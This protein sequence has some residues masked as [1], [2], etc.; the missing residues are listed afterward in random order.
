MEEVYQYIKDIKDMRVKVTTQRD[1][2]FLLADRRVAEKIG[3]FIKSSISHHTSKIGRIKETMSCCYLPVL[4]DKLV[5]EKFAKIQ[6]PFEMTILAK[7]GYISL[8]TLA[9][10]FS[11][12]GSKLTVE[13]VKD[14][15]CQNESDEVPRYQWNWEDDSVFKPYDKSVSAKLEKAFLSGLTIVEHIGRFQYKIDS[16]NMEQTN[17]RTDRVRKIERKALYESKVWGISLEIVAHDKHL[18]EIKREV[19]KE[20]EKVVVETEFTES[21][22]K[23]VPKCRDSLLEVA[24][25]NLVSAENVASNS[26]AIT[27]KGTPDIVKN[28]ELRLKEEI[29]TKQLEAASASSVNFPTCWEP[30]EEKCELKIVRKGTLEWKSVEQ[31][32]KEPGFHIQIISIERIQNIWLWEA[33]DQSRKRMSDKNSGQVNEK[34]L[35]HGTRT[36]PPKKIYNSEQG[37]DNRLSSTGVW[38]IGAYF[39]VRA[40]YSDKYAHTTP[41]GN[42]QMF[43][44]HVITGITCRCPPN[45]TLKAPP[46]KAE[47]STPLSPISKDS[48]FEDERY[49]SVAG[50][51]GVSDIFVIYEQGKVYPAYLIT[52][53]R[54][55]I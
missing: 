21:Y 3:H 38:G 55:Y 51:T 44:A 42:R 45:N 39:A 50:K 15:L 41:E 14:Y 28:T 5:Q 2:L 29:L 36:T 17:L 7:K 12:C 13:S 27:L 10:D 25:L 49:D 18:H 53:R 20:M 33:F 32:M 43:L 22:M 35:F 24:R 8:E 4:A 31:H 40:Q 11:K 46:T 26:H 52:Y 37:F 9:K 54:T 1:A 16:S 6:V 47:V 19:L 30:Q 48:M 23:K 34:Q